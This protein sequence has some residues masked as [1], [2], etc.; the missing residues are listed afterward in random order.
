MKKIKLEA[1][2]DEKTM[3]VHLRENSFPFAKKG[4][5]GNWDFVKIRNKK[6]T[7][8]EIEDLSKEI[9]E[10]GEEGEEGFVEIQRTGSTIAQLGTFRIVITRPPFSDG[11]EIT[12]VRPVKHLK[13]ADYDLSPK[14]LERLDKQAE[15]III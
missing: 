8:T 13:L 1:F 6:L 14:L 3:S 15:G 11:W 7:R 2:F 9:I 4:S 10:I 5:P 12:A